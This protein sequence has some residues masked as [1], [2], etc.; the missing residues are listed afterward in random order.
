M[1]EIKLTTRTISGKKVNQLRH[2]GLIPAV[3]YGH[4]IKT[5]SAQVDY[6]TFDKIY[7]QVGSSTLVDLI[8]GDNKPVKALIQDVA[9]N[10]VT[11]KYQHVDF[12]QVRMDEKISAEVPIVF[13]GE[14]KAVK[15]LGGILLKNMNFIKIECLPQDLQHEIQVD[16][17]PLDDFTKTIQ[18]KDL[19]L[20][21]SWDVLA[22]TD[23]LVV[24]VEEPRA[25]EE[26]TTAPEADVSQVEG[27]A[28]KP[29]AGEGAEGVAKDAKPAKDRELKTEGKE[30]K[31]K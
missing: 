16:L 7:R 9:I 20:A 12:H 8:L 6:L 26:V 22:N 13:I 18:V 29:A 28:D 1:P 23:E 3:I 5:T 19:K 21:A 15:E 27:V 10:P 2:Q 11:S 30:K 4:G 24:G 14:S 25:Q 17:T 31:S